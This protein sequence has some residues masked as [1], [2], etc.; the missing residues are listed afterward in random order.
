MRNG[1][2]KIKFVLFIAFL[3]LL[4]LPF[5]QSE[6]SLV[7]VGE[8]EGAF[9]EKGKP[10]LTTK[11]WIS[12]RF[13]LQAEEYINESFGFRNLLVRLNN[14][15]AFSFFSKA[16]AD[17]IV[18]GR[19]N[20]LYQRPSI[21]AYFGNNFIGDS[22][23][24]ERIQRLKFIS[25]TLSKLNKNLIVVFGTGKGS[26]YPEYIPKNL[27]QQK[28]SSNLEY[29][30][31]YAK[32]YGIHNI[33]FN[34]YLISMKN[35]S[36]Y[37][38]YPQ[39]GIHW[40]RYG[41]LLVTDSI[42]RYIEEIRKVDLPQP[43]IDTILIGQPQNEDYDIAGGMNLLFRLKSF[44]MAYPKIHFETDSGKTKPSLLVIG[45]SFYWACQNMDI[46]K[47][48]SKHQFWFYNKRGTAGALKELSE[49]TKLEMAKEI[50][51]FDIVILIATEANIPELGWGFIENTF[52]YY[53]G[54]D[55]EHLADILLQEE[56]TFLKERI[57]TN[58]RRM[59]QIKEL[60]LLNKISVDSM[61]TLQ[62]IKR[63]KKKMKM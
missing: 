5:I 22:R 44:D 21:H 54:M 23:T 17:N 49:E 16:N 31:K 8:L 6:I 24:E 50:N 58:P 33:D 29:H 40:S 20:Y 25:D 13:Q 15:I 27:T 18:V 3:L 14:Q 41:G 53:K 55:A 51:S 57:K 28:G 26:Y 56:I 32:K 36:A 48:F 11:E 52:A 19:N 34:E 37:P 59:E 35:S 42:I 46:S 39:Y 61:L 63:A 2:S 7:N 30:L 38:L 4:T 1:K 43:I 9:I 62:A 47:A 12:G 60:A 10:V 45:D